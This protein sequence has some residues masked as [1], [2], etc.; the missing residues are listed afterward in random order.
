MVPASDVD[1]AS[2]DDPVRS[3]KVQLVYE[4]AQYVGYEIDETVSPVDKLSKGLL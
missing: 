1:A 2:G 4:A 3:G